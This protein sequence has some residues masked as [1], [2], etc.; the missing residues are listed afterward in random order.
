MQ[1]QH[2]IWLFHAILATG[3]LGINNI[4][5]DPDGVAREYVVER[6]DYG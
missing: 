3:R 6:F 5:P 4:Y 1:L 2:S